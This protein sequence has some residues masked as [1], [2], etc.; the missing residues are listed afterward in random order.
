MGHDARDWEGHVDARRRLR[1]RVVFNGGL[2]LCDCFQM[3]L[4]VVLSV[5]G[6]CLSFSNVGCYPV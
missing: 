3:E 1:H 2:G 6:V 4:V 5:V